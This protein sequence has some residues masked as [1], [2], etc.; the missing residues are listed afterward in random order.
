MDGNIDFGSD[1]F[2]MILMNNTFV[3]DRDSH[4]T[5]SDVSADELAA[6][7]GYALSGELLISGEL[8]EDDANDRGKMT[9]S[10]ASWTA[11]SGDIGPTGSAVMIDFT[12]ADDTVIGCVDYGSDYTIADASSFLIKDIA[13]ATS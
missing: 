10:D 9:W 3:F 4:A 7:N 2:R 6:G 8:T 12:S 1:T 5:Y 11:S 13:V